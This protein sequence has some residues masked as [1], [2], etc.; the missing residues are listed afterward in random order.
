MLSSTTRLGAA[1]LEGAARSPRVDLTVSAALRFELC[2]MQ[3]AAVT[4]PDWLRN[5]AGL[6]QI[7]YWTGTLEPR[8][9]VDWYGAIMTN[10]CLCLWLFRSCIAS[11]H[12][13]SLS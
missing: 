3:C 10:L 2:C 1:A 4:R 9:T 6:R 12:C 11:V 8:P 13:V 7:E 5:A